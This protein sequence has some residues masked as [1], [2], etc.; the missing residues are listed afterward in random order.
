[1]SFRQELDDFG[2][3]Y[4]RTYQM[5]YRTAYGIVGEASVASDVTQDAFY[6][7]YKTRGSFRGDSPA[8]SWLLRIVVNGA[9]S[10][11]RRPRPEVLDLNP[12]PAAAGL[13]HVE[14]LEL[15]TAL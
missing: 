1:M 10:A 11:R 9:I 7:A 6:K 13:G 14:R 3:F 15:A 8:R 4:E 12:E 5:A 2:A